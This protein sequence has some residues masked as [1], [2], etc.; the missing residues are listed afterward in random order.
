[1][2]IYDKWHKPPDDARLVDYDSFEELAGK[3]LKTQFDDQEIQG[4]FDNLRKA[5]VK[6]YIDGGKDIEYFSI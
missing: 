3:Y 5:L 4:K 1:M 6:N 2:R